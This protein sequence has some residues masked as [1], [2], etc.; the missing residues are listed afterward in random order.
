[1]STSLVTEGPGDLI[2]AGEEVIPHSHEGATTI[3]D[4]LFLHLCN[5]SSSH[6]W[7]AKD[8]SHLKVVVHWQ[9]LIEV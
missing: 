2:R 1:M 9:V 4:D 7:V 6:V 5:E 8:P 3:K